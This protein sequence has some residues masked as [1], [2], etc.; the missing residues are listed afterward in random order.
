MSGASVLIDSGSRSAEAR[1]GGIFATKFDGAWMF[2][3]ADEAPPAPGYWYDAHRCP[4]PAPAGPTSAQIGPCMRCRQ[5]HHRYGDGGS[6][7]C[8][9]CS[10]GV[11]ATA[12]H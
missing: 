8:A 4:D 9:T 11:A 7:L 1:A 12:G 5:P 2:H 3:R 6:P 10:T